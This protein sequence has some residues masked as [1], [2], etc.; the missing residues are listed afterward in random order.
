MSDDVW[1]AL[2]PTCSHCP[3]LRFEHDEAGLCRRCDCGDRP[4]SRVPEIYTVEESGWG[5]VP[6]MDH[7][8]G[9]GDVEHDPRR[10]L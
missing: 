2:V 1:D 7:I 10:F 9:R 6:G 8:V 5:G 4:I 3:H